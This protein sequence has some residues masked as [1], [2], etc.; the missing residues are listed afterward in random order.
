MD[1]SY[2]ESFKSNIETTLDQGFGTGF[3]HHV[4]AG[5]RFLMRYYDSV[6]THAPCPLWPYDSAN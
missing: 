5:Y 1:Q 6:P 3:D 2:W 4:L